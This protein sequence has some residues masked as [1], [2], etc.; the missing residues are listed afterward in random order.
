MRIR[1]LIRLSIVRYTCE[2]LIRSKY[3]FFFFLYYTSSFFPLRRFVFKDSCSHTSRCSRSEIHKNPSMTYIW[4]P[5]FRSWS[6]IAHSCLFAL[7]SWKRGFHIRK[8]SIKLRVQTAITS[9]VGVLIGGYLVHIHRLRFFLERL[10]DRLFR[11]GLLQ[12]SY[13]K[14]QLRS[15]SHPWGRFLKNVAYNISWKSMIYTD[16]KR[17]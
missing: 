14:F 17:K 12:N 6:K 9:D 13:P 8:H 15:V 1:S 7:I 5:T 3:F 16:R 11:H 10:V 4:S 2:I